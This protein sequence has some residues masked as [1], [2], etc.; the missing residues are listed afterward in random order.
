MDKQETTT[1]MPYSDA[2]EEF[3]RRKLAA[4]KTERY[5]DEVADMLM[6]FGAGPEKQ[7]IHEILPGGTLSTGSTRTRTGARAPGVRT[8]L[9]S[10][11][12]RRSPFPKGGT[13]ST[14]WT[15][16]SRS[17]FQGPT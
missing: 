10:V 2:V 9:G 6:K 13:R 17:Q 8:C 16:W 15:A 5:V 3:K 4:G 14:S 12:C 1:P 11:A 7:N